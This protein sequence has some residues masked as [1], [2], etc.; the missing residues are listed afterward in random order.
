MENVFLP[1]ILITVTLDSP[2]GVAG[3]NIVLSS[4]F[5]IYKYKDNFN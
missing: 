2:I 5:I 4:D 1:L 3:A